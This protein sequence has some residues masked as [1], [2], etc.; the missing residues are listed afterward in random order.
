MSL[1]IGFLALTGLVFWLVV[2]AMLIFI[3]ME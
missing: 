1:L 3:W 2:I